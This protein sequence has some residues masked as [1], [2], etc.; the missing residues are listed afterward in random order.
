MNNQ[1]ER[2][3]MKH[4]KTPHEVAARS[5]GKPD[6][7]SIEVR[8]Y[9]LYLERGGESGHDSED[10]LRAETELAGRCEAAPAQMAR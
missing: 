9:E 5:E 1:N 7:K 2:K 3:N 8:A 4:H 6:P 10:W